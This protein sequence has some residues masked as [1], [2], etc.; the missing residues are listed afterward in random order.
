MNGALARAVHR[1]LLAGQ[2]AQAFTRKVRQKS[3]Q[4][5]EQ[6]PGERLLEQEKLVGPLITQVTN[7]LPA[8]KRKGYV[9]RPQSFFA[10]LQVEHEDVIAMR[11]DRA[12]PLLIEETRTTVA[13]L[14]SPPSARASANP[15]A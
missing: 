3:K 11:H 12:D 13:S 7:H 1:S 10:G 5:G 9:L 15:S 2:R 14:L 4:A 6:G 8:E